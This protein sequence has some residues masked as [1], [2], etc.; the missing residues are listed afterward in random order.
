MA[1]VTVFTDGKY[2]PNSYIV[3]KVVDG[4][5]DPYNQDMTRLVQVDYDFPGLASTFGFIPCRKCN[6]TDG[7]ISCKHHTVT[8]MISRARQFLDNSIGIIVDDPGY[9]DC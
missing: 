2:A 4:K 3:C 6:F 8:D 9:F 5:Y 7:T 1:Q